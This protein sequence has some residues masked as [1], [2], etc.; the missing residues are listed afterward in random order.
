[1]ERKRAE[2][3]MKNMDPKKAEQ[4][5]RLGM[6]MTGSRYSIRFAMFNFL[7]LIPNDKI[8]SLYLKQTFIIPRINHQLF[9]L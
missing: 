7:P 6:G 2:D 1:M 4:L 8:F 5:Q 9:A 3:Q